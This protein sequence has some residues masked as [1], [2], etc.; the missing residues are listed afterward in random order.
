[1]DTS[2]GSCLETTKYCCINCQLAVCNR[3]STFE[4]NEETV[5]WLAGR[6][7][8][9]CNVCAGIEERNKSK[10][11]NDDYDGDLRATK[12]CTKR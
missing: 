8:G 9:Y 1:M 2:C 11:R 10:G 4:M 7:V 12:S 3:C 6:R 5:G